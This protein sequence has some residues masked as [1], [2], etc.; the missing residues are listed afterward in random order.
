[1]TQGNSHPIQAFA[2]ILQ[3]LPDTCN[4]PNFNTTDINL[5]E[6]ARKKVGESRFIDAV[7]KMIISD[8]AKNNQKLLLHQFILYP[9]ILN[10]SLSL[11][12]V[13]INRNSKN[14]SVQE[15][16]ALFRYYLA[17]ATNITAKFDDKILTKG[18]RECKSLLLKANYVIYYVKQLFNF[19]EN[20]SPKFLIQDKKK[21][22]F[23]L[24]Y[25]TSPQSGVSSRM[26]LALLYQILEEFI[27]P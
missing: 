5:L 18:S 22:G 27:S 13:F 21:L 11:R 17:L 9:K 23:G 8:L 14:A 20:S 7:T 12:N 10:T 6:Y 26:H 15:S 19:N 16:K 4:L 24:V 1:M 2:E 3:K 25:M